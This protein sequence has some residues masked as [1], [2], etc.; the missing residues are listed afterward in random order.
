VDFNVLDTQPVEAYNS[1]PVILGHPF[2]ARWSYPLETL[3][4]PY[5]SIVL[6]IFT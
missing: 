2:L 1:I 4:Q 6:L 5:Y 3:M